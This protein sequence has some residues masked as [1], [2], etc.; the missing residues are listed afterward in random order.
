MTINPFDYLFFKISELQS[1][2]WPNTRMYDSTLTSLCL[3]INIL[4]VLMLIF[5]DLYPIFLFIELILMFIITIFYNNRSRRERILTKYSQESE[6]SRI[7][8]NTLVIIY[9][10]ITVASFIGAIFWV[11]YLKS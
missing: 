11:R 8:G 2:H 4:S 9:A 10:I 7:I 3:G 1:I 5:G 6:K